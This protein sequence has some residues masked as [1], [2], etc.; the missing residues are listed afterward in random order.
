MNS[1]AKVSDIT[2]SDLAEYIRL[3]DPDTNDNQ[4]LENLLSVSKN[5]ISQYTGQND[6]DAFKDFVIAVFVLV[7]DMWDNRSLYVEK[8]NL[9]EVVSR[10]LDMH[11]V[12]LL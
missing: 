7:Q 8:N 6:L 9:N 1:I 2:A 11:A 4:L 10:I 12:N 5:F 3:P